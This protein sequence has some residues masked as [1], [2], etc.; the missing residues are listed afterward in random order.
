VS[1]L[2]A[3]AAAV[4]DDRDF[5]DILQMHYAAARDVC[6]YPPRHMCDQLAM[7]GLSTSVLRACFVQNSGRVVGGSSLPPS[8]SRVVDMITE[9]FRCGDVAHRF[10]TACVAVMNLLRVEINTPDNSDVWSGIDVM[11][12]TSQSVAAL[13]IVS[14]ESVSTLRSSAHSSHSVDLSLVVPNRAC[15]ALRAPRFLCA[16]RKAVANGALV[17]GKLR[18]SILLSSVARFRS[19]KR[20]R[21]AAIERETLCPLADRAQQQF[22]FNNDEYSSIQQDSITPFQMVQD[23][24]LQFVSDDSGQHNRHPCVPLQLER[25]YVIMKCLQR[26][27]PDGGGIV[28]LKEIGKKLM[29]EGGYFHDHSERSV[30]QSVSWVVKKCE[31]KAKAKM[32]T[33][34]KLEYVKAA[35]GVKGGGSLSLDAMGARG[36]YAFLRTTLLSMET[37]DSTFMN[38]WHVSRSSRNKAK[39]AA[40]LKAVGGSQAGKKRPSKA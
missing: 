15:R 26:M 7:V 31:E 12:S 34:G 9:F 14:P 8:S 17:P 16:L 11:Q 1:A 22:P 28:T 19:D 21:A 23:P 2:A 4:S 20:F 39:S 6:A 5:I 37:A 33:D 35:T 3:I 25:D 38:A 40:A 10:R 27:I 36:L 32:L 13:R 29:S 24:A 30:E 18:A